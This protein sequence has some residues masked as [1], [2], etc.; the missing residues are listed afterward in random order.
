MQIFTTAEARPGVG[1]S[2]RKPEA[3]FGIDSHLCVIPAT[4][5]LGSS[6]GRVRLRAAA[7]HPVP[8]NG[9]SH[10]WACLEGG[11]Q[12]FDGSAE[13]AMLAS[14]DVFAPPAGPELTFQAVVDSVLVRVAD[15]ASHH[16]GPAL[17]SSGEFIALE[18]GQ[19]DWARRF[20]A[21][22][23][24]WAACHHGV[25]CLQWRE[26]RDPDALHAAWLR[27]G[28][29]FA[30]ASDD[31]Y[32][33]DAIDTGAGLLCCLRPRRVVRPVLTHAWPARQ[34]LIDAGTAWRRTGFRA[35][36]PT[37]AACVPSP[38]PPRRA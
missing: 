13:C 19:P 30:P 6:A 21:R 23:L 24:I 11:V 12:V 34:R 37:A 8:A 22:G 38:A 16:G 3:G 1:I 18:P 28:M 27:P 9:D 29:A 15:I 26:A 20:A 35:P 4:A 25:L 17:P 32:C 14:G 33:I 10:W 2:P 36:C 5:D 31:D 7:R